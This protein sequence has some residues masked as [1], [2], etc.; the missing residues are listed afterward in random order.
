MLIRQPSPQRSPRGRGRSV[1]SV[2]AESLVLH[3]RQDYRSVGRWMAT[4]PKVT[5]EQFLAMGE[6]KPYSEYACGEVIQKP[7][8][9]VSHSAIQVFVTAALA[10]FLDRTGIG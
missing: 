4:S 1:S 9:D 5:L 2:I 6:T 10:R 8:G 3:C 7:Y